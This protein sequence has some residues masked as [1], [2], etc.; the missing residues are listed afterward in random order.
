MEAEI[1]IDKKNRKFLP[2][3]YVS[4][5][6]SQLINWIKYIFIIRL[7]FKCLEKEKCLED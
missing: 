6:K 1:D 3:V 4:L 2:Y 7:L 5:L